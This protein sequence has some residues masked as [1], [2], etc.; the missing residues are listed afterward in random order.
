ML[1]QYKKIQICFS[2]IINS[3]LSYFQVKAHTIFIIYK[4]FIFC[5]CSSSIMQECVIIVL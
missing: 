2:F 1:K 3:L 5:N 4:L